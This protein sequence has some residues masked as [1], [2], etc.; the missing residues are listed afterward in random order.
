[1]GIQDY[2][3]KKIQ[4]NNEYCHNLTEMAQ[5]MREIAKMVKKKE[6]KHLEYS[7]KIEYR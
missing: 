2:S 7:I 3:N 4:I 1:M 5:E 6:I